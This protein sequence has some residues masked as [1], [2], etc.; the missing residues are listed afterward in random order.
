MTCSSRRASSAENSGHQ[1]G[2]AL[3]WCCVATSP[4]SNPPGNAAK[5][6]T[7]GQSPRRPATERDQSAYRLE[8]NHRGSS[9][10]T[11]SSILGP[12]T[13]AVGERPGSWYVAAW[14]MRVGAL[15][16]RQ[17]SR[18]LIGSH[19]AGAPVEVV[20]R[21]LASVWIQAIRVS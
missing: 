14:P 21:V 10:L 12:S 8:G 16:R 1:D 4:T 13:A 5:P 2:C 9:T 18:A 15:R 6:P 11:L 20:A 7:N 17:P 3:Y 19:L